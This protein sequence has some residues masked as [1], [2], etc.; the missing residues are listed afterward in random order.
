[1]QKNVS[2]S[3]SYLRKAITVDEAARQW[4]LTDDDL[5]NLRGHSEFKKIV[6][7]GTDL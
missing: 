3:L 6:N 5:K 1:L 2:Q 7:S 4:A